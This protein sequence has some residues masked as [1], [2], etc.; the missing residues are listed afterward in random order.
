MRQAGFELMGLVA[1]F[2]VGHRRFETM[3]VAMAAW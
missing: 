2:G 1:R 3:R